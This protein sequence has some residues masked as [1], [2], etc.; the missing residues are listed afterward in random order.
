M[1][2]KILEGETFRRYESLA[3]SKRLS[4]EVITVQNAILVTAV[5]C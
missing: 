3:F 4:L 5:P 1:E 2:S